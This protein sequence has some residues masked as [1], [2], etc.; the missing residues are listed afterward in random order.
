MGAAYSS[1]GRTK[2]LYA[3]SF[4]LLG[5]KAKF[6]RRKP[7]VL[8]A[9]EEISETCWESTGEETPPNVNTRAQT[10]R[11][12][13][14]HF[15]ELLRMQNF[16]FNLEGKWHSGKWQRIY[17]TCMGG[18]WVRMDVLIIISW[19]EMKSVINYNY[20]VCNIVQF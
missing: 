18:G 12:D 13:R 1:L 9:L 15:N 20:T 17:Y 14:E 10:S 6:L 2:V 7:S 3:T 5:A 8:V 4:V 16:T 11:H 19:M